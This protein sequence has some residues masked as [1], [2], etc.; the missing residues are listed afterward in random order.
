M[1][2][3]G[4]ALL[5]VLVLC[6]V[7]LIITGT[8]VSYITKESHFSVR[9]DESTKAYAAA[10]SGIE[11]GK[12]EYPNLSIG[13]T[14]KYIKVQAGTD[15]TA[16]V[17]VTKNANSGLIE[18]TGTSGEVTRKLEYTVAK[19]NFSPV[20]LNTSPEL[21]EVSSSNTGSFT[22]K[23]HYWYQAGVSAPQMTFGVKDPSIANK[24]LA[25][26][27][28]SN[29]YAKI[30]AGYG[31]ATPKTS[32]PIKLPPPDATVNHDKA[33]TYEL[34]LH[35]IK[36]I[37]ASLRIKEVKKN[38]AN[39]AYKECIFVTSDGYVA[40]GLVGLDLGNL[41]NIKAIS[42][43][44]TTTVTMIPAANDK[45]YNTDYILFKDTS[46]NRFGYIANI[47]LKK[48]NAAA[49][50]G[51]GGI[52]PGGGGVPPGGGGPGPTQYILWVFVNPPPE[53]PPYI[54]GVC[55]DTQENHGYCPVESDGGTYNEGQT[56]TASYD[57]STILNGWVFTGWSGDCSG[58]SESV[59]VV[60][61]SEKTC[62]A[63]F[64]QSS[65]GGGGSQ[66]VYGCTNPYA[67][68]Y[69][70]DATIDNDS[71]AWDASSCA[72]AG[73]FFDEETAPFCFF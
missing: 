12:K 39:E 70:P 45:Y 33:F 18:S 61:N 63:N 46:N 54:A 52:P 44:G 47:L 19:E 51:G 41:K 1:R 32:S 15:I 64:E 71:C 34:E 49:G 30:V 28:D 21:T 69:N 67:T 31:V 17:I 73:G 60:M 29:G 16:E 4:V 8:M 62:I 68:N 11:W 65:S 24:Y 23:F 43:S 55:A 14:T 26:N 2:K 48:T 13:Q 50:G 35:Y 40:V 57:P 3:K 38:A 27:V 42:Q 59:S 9:V 20:P 66:E 10:S 58:T 25:V 56:G 6:S 53:Q 36:G 22:L 5:W 37:G 72:I 7:L